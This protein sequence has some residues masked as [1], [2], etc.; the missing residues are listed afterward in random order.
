MNIPIQKFSDYKC[1]TGCGGIRIAYMQTLKANRIIEPRAMSAFKSSKRTKQEV[2]MF[3][4]TF[5]LQPHQSPVSM[6]LLIPPA[7]PHPPVRQDAQPAT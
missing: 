7:L 6:Y 4:P 2:I 3:I 1:L 5:I